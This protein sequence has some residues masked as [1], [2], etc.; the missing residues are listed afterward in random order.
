MESWFLL[1]Y[2]SGWLLLGGGSSGI[3]GLVYL[4][5]H[6]NYF[7]TKGKTIERGV[8][9]SGNGTVAFAGLNLCFLVGSFAVPAG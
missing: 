5:Q 4:G 2:L 7:A 6:H 9:F 1:G 8:G 3:C